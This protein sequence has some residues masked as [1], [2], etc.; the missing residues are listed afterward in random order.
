LTPCFPCGDEDGIRNFYWKL[1]PARL[2]PESHELWIDN[3]I[4]ITDRI[5]KID[6]WLVG[7]TGL[8]GTGFNRDYGRFAKTMPDVTLAYCAGMFGLPPGF[9]LET[10]IVEVVGNRTITGFDE[11]GLVVRIVTGIDNFLTLEQKDMAL[12]SER[13]RPK[14]MRGFPH[15]LHF[16]RV[17]RFDFHHSWRA[18]RFV[19]MP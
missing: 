5:K 10:K 9:D 15:G 17:N 16:A 7:S 19:V 4:V 2:R 11:Q 6:D 14:V 13:W 12:L 8:I 3:D 18:Y 1:I